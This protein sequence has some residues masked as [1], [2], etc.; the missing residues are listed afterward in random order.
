[1]RLG[2]IG[3][4][5]VVLLGAGADLVLA[6]RWFGGLC[7]SSMKSLLAL[8][9]LAL[10]PCAGAAP[11]F[12]NPA[13]SPD[14]K[15]F[16][17]DRPVR[18]LFGGYRAINNS[19]KSGETRFSSSQIRHYGHP[20]LEKFQGEYYWAL[21]VTIEEAGQAPAHY[22]GKPMGQPTKVIQA[23]ALVRFGKVHHW[24]YQNTHPERS[25]IPLR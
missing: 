23:R 20:N 16:C 10:C 2:A 17:G 24:F 8:V 6:T 4:L 12:S 22:A 13:P 3:S 1:M 15:P 14:A 21:P 7:S 25:W 18:L 5:V 11:V 9:L 19:I